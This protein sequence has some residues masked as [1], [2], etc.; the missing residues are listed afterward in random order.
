MRRKA[1]VSETFRR[2]YIPTPAS[3]GA[4]H[5]RDPRPA[6]REKIGRLDEGRDS[7]ERGLTE[8]NTG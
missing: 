7:G 4:D 6:P 1:G 5:E 8:H 2:M 3:S